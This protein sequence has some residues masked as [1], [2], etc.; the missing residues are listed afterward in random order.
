MRQENRSDI[1]KI[2]EPHNEMCYKET[3]MNH[4]IHILTAEAM[5]EHHPSTVMVMTTRMDESEMQ[6]VSL[7]VMHWTNIN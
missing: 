5:T 6:Y 1:I 4:V 7:S 3:Y 2:T